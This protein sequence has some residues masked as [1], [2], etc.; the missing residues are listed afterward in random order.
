MNSIKL[1]IASFLRI[2]LV[3]VFV[4]G[5]YSPKVFAVIEKDYNK[6]IQRIS[7]DYTKKFCNGIAF[8]L[9]KESAMNFA[10]KENNQVFQN[11]NG[12]GELNEELV[13][14]N[15]SNLV[16]DRCGYPI[17]LKGEEGIKEFKNDYISMNSSFFDNE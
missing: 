10:M 4:L 8:G 13:A 1:V 9:S 2:I 5:S 12:F 6:L 14:E 16:V 17:N 3:F 15:I 7:K 11:K